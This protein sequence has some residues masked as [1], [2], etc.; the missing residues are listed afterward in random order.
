MKMKY[1]A[2]LR[3]QPNKIK[4]SQQASYF[5]DAVVLNA[6]NNIDVVRGLVAPP[7][8]AG[9]RDEEVA[10]WGVADTRGKDSLSSQQD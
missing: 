7:N 4:R 10:H 9:S 1:S 8:K 5:K 3:V 2:T 6:C